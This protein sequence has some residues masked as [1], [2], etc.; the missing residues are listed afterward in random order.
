MIC[1]DRT[2]GYDRKFLEEHVETIFLENRESRL[3]LSPELQSRVMT[4]SAAGD[5]G[6][7]FGWINYDLIKS[8][9]RLKHCNN[10]G[11][12]DRY[13]IGPEGGQFSIFFNPG[14]PFDFE[15][16]QTPSPIDS[17]EWEITRRSN[18][19]VNMRKDMSLHNYSGNKFELTADREIK[20]MGIE[21]IEY[22]FDEKFPKGLSVVGFNSINKMTNKGDYEWNRETGMLSIWVLSQLIPS[23]KNTVIIPVKRSYNSEY[24]NDSYFGK[25]D[26]KRIRFLDRSILFRADGK[27]RG[28]IGISPKV[29]LPV[30][31]SYDSQNSVLTL[32][33]FSLDETKEDY[34]N[35]GW[36]IQKEPFK[37]DV[38]NSYN[39]GPLPNGEIMGPFYEIETSSAAA[40]LKPGESI[41][42]K[43]SILHIMGKR[44]EL[45]E[46]L[47]KTLNVD[48]KDLF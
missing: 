6:Y 3:I 40:E 7:S 16:W 36:I 4:S 15:H 44:D 27:K 43:H 32:V 34:V 10:F 38:I 31:G 33:K 46:I 35:S 2:F 47:S 18:S 5:T 17:E 8:G 19:S 26:Q 41:L 39:D 14:D 24:I 37:G 13:W 9:K 11:G 28:K 30:L 23:G 21:E 25:I 22:E 12:E 1:R 29:A 42:H 48:P 20:L 45:E